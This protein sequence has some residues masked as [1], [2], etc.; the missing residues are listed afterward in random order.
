MHM[1]VQLPHRL[2]R[3]LDGFQIQEDPDLVRFGPV[4]EGEV[5]P[6][7]VLHV[8]EDSVGAC[9]VVSTEAGNKKW[10]ING[11][12]QFVNFYFSTPPVC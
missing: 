1:L 11:N 2:L 5:G 7:K 6:E 4:G 12:I 3:R 10:N 9:E 8:E